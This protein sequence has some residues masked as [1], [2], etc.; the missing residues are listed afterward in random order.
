MKDAL[1][2]KLSTYCSGKCRLPGRTWLMVIPV[3]REAMQ[4]GILKKVPI[5]VLI[6]CPES[7]RGAAASEV[8]ACQ[9]LLDTKESET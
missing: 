5:A 4:P 3:A 2:L 6:F 8:S 7:K 9:L 1:Y